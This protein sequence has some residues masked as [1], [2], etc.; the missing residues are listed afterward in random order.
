MDPF[1]PMFS[2]AKELGLAKPRAKFPNSLEWSLFPKLY[3]YILLWQIL[4]CLGHV[5]PAQLTKPNGIF[6]NKIQS[7]QSDLARKQYP[8][9][10]DQVMLQSFF[11]V[12]NY[13][14]TI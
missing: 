11:V 10:L 8:D 1:A 14:R 7:N 2:L 6:H 3:S 12:Q 5:T 9:K 13:W 4:I